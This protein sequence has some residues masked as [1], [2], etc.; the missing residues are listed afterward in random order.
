MKID[1]SHSFS[2]ILFLCFFMSN[3]ASATALD[4]LQS[5]LNV[6]KAK[7]VELTSQL[8]GLAGTPTTGTSGSLPI[9]GTS[10]ST[11]GTSQTAPEH[12]AEALA[13]TMPGGLDLNG[14]IEWT[15]NHIGTL[16]QLLNDAVE[17]TNQQSE[18]ILVP[19]STIAPALF[20]KYAH[21]VDPYFDPNSDIV[22]TDL[23]HQ[24]RFDETYE[25][26]E[27][28]VSNEIT[29]ADV[30]NLKVFVPQ[31]IN[32]VLGKYAEF[33]EIGTPKI[34][35]GIVTPYDAGNARMA[36]LH[37]LTTSNIY[38][39]IDIHSETVF[40]ILTHTAQQANLVL[41]IPPLGE[42]VL[43]QLLPNE[44]VGYELLDLITSSQ[45]LLRNPQKYANKI[46]QIIDFCIVLFS[47]PIPPNNEPAK[48]FEDG[49]NLL[50]AQLK[51]QRGSLLCAYM[52]LKAGSENPLF[53]EWLHHEQ[54]LVWALKAAMYY[55]DQEPQYN[56]TPARTEL[57]IIYEILKH[58]QRSKSGSDALLAACRAYIQDT[59]N[60][61]GEPNEGKF[62]KPEYGNHGWQ[63]KRDIFRTILARKLLEAAYRYEAG[64]K[65]ARQKIAEQEAL[66]IHLDAQKRH[67]EEL[68][69]QHQAQEQELN[70]KKEED[71]IAALADAT[72]QQEAAAAL[73]LANKERKRQAQ[74]D[75]AIAK[76]QED[77]AEKQR[78]A[79]LQTTFQQEEFKTTQTKSFASNTKASINALRGWIE[80]TLI[81]DAQQSTALR[82]GGAPYIASFNV[83]GEATTGCKKTD[84]IGWL[85]WF[86]KC[87]EE[88][89]DPSTSSSG[90]LQSL[91]TQTIGAD[92]CY[93]T[94]MKHTTIIVQNILHDADSLRTNLI[95]INSEGLIPITNFC[96]L[97]IEAEKYNLAD[98]S[99]PADY[100]LIADFIYL[101]VIPAS[102]QDEDRLK[103]IVTRIAT[104][105]D[106][107][108]PFA[109]KC[110]TLV[111]MYIKEF[112]KLNQ[113]TA[114]RN[115][116]IG[117]PSDPEAQKLTSAIDTL[118]A[119]SGPSIAASSQ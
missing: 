62:D 33:K 15:R 76:A 104:A 7:L 63:I 48:S 4:D 19:T 102:G 74:K 106:R 89:Q 5:T 108:K 60:V 36:L 67:Q 45:P 58:I 22:A 51:L 98:F 17:E 23:D 70:R 46:R 68:E 53:L 40:D 25:A 20:N 35:L 26:F 107:L 90:I 55:I 9:T 110:A 10:S 39:Q 94:A 49:Y 92:N 16:R 32:T 64:E 54:F 82:P 29:E 78:L 44:M 28:F 8:S 38:Q 50:I 30:A 1:R 116:L 84:I 83:T 100:E 14:Q 12:L 3:Y 21:L 111:E 113:L 43:E 57:Y 37:S 2:I 93:E 80:K 99:V 105:P 11:S 18:T 6:L 75:A 115:A 41:Q 72:A 88:A 66:I 69:R 85:K 24:E 103:D 34:G 61:E 77:A 117:Y 81:P 86:V 71:R 65:K 91:K 59:S 114:I 56:D 101:N 73:K 118:P 96:K 87:H 112:Y 95:Q 79:A 42:I 52:L 97:V 13:Q 27:N 109:R 47:K 31:Y 119:S